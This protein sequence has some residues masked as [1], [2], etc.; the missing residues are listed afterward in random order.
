MALEQLTDVM[1]KGEAFANI[2][3]LFV[4]YFSGANASPLQDNV[5]R[6]LD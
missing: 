3:Y 6:S 2:G 1:G 4:P 5:V